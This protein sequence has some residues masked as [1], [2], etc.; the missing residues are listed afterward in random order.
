MK[1]AAHRY[2]EKTGDI[3][4]TASACPTRSHNKDYARYLLT[5]LYFES[6]KHGQWK[7]IRRAEN[8]ATRA[9]GLSL[10]RIKFRASYPSE[11][12]KLSVKLV[13]N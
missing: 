3:K 6:I 11:S 13:R 5:A 8:L 10:T 2:D 9:K 1:L 12:I 7:I 4:I